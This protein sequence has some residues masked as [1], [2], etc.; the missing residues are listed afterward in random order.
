VATDEAVCWGEVAAEDAVAR[1]GTAEERPWWMF[2]DPWRGSVR[3]GVAVVDVG[4]RFSPPRSALFRS[5]P[6]R[7]RLVLI[8]ISPPRSA[9]A[10][11]ATLILSIVLTS[12]T[13]CR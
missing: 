5:D 12:C 2:V 13:L 9:S 6:L 1:G 10:S 7:S 3:E 11:L 8:L 4:I